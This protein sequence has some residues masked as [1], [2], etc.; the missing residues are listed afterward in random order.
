MGAR[1][2]APTPTA[3]LSARGS[4]R[5]KANRDEPR[6][7]RGKP[8]CPKSLPKAARA[9]WNKLCRQLDDMG[10]LAKIDGGQLERYCVYFL[11]WQE[12]EAFIAKHGMS[13]PVKNDEPTNYVGKLQATESKDATAVV[14]FREYPQVRESHR[15]DKALKH[16]EANF[17]LTPSARARLTTA[18]GP[19][20]AASTVGK[21]R[22]FGGKTG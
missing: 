14:S 15:L 11:R 13:Y 18:D 5:A 7:E 4:W 20:P 8:S 17:G 21:G 6:P 1:G 10:V 12:C 22:F 19:A 3:I 2:P 16:I 9:L